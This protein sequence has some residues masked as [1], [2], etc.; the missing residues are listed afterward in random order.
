MKVLHSFTHALLIAAMACTLTACGGGD[1]NQPDPQPSPSPTPSPVTN[2]YVGTWLEEG[3]SGCE[4]SDFRLA[5]TG[6]RLF[7]RYTLELI[8]AG[9]QDLQARQVST[10]YEDARCTVRVGVKE[11]NGSLRYQGERVRNPGNQQ[12]SVDVYVYRWERGVLRNEQTGEEAPMNTSYRTDRDQQV[13]GFLIYAR[14]V[15]DNLLPP[16]PLEQY[17]D[18][19][20]QGNRLYIFDSNDDDDYGEFFRR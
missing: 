3:W 17:T 9:G 13:A 12:V 6:Q 15:D 18:L 2:K 5:S 20:V 11:V 10:I 16:Y 4:D 7:E 8:A 19:Y 1:D 14:D